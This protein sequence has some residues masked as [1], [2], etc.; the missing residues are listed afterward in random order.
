M[1][2][3][4][5]KVR[6]IIFLEVSMK[7][8]PI[9]ILLFMFL[10]SVPVRANES[11]PSLSNMPLLTYSMVYVRTDGQIALITSDL[12]IRADT[13]VWFSGHAKYARVVDGSWTS[14]SD[15]N[16][17][18]YVA[19]STSYGSI[20]AADHD[21]YKFDGTTLFFSAPENYLVTVAE[22]GQVSLGNLMTDFGAVLGTLLPVGLILSSMVLALYLV[23]RFLPWFGLSSR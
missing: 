12:P 10:F 9:I 15:I 21:I 18:G 8:F 19:V 17:S 5:F 23:R 22:M 7:K 1:I 6:A 20:I 16:G 14:F 13:K 3:L 2:A 11:Y 4:A